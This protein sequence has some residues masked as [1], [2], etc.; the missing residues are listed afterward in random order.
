MTTPDGLHLLSALDLAAAYRSGATSP[1][2]V[3]D[4]LLARVDTHA[5]TLGAFVTVTADRARAQALQA[6]QRFRDGDGDRLPPLYGVPTAIKDLTMTAGVRTMFGSAVMREHVPTVSDEVVVRIEAAGLISLGKTNTP[7]FGSPCYTEPDVAP[8]AR[9]PYDL[10]RSAGGSSGGAAAAV[11][12]GLVPVAHGSDGGGSIRIPASVCGLVGFKPT[13]GRIS[14][15]PVHGD[16]SGLST[17]GC[18]ATTVRD[19]AALLDVMAGHHPGDPTWAPPLP[20]GQTY[21]GWCDRTPAPL[22][23]GCF[24]EP[25][26]SDCEL[27]PHVRGA[28][29][30][31]REL[32]VGLGHEVVDIGPP[33]R[34]RTAVPDF[35]V[36]WAV[37]TTGIPVPVE[38]EHLLRPLTRWLRERGARTS[39]AQYQAA[40]V[41]MRQAA[42]SAQVALH[43]YDAVLTPTLGQLPALVSGLRNDQDPAADFA[44]QKDFTPFTAAWNVTGMPA[45][46]MPTGW[47]GTGLPIGT[48][49][50]GRAGEDHLLLAIAAQVEAALPPLTRAVLG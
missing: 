7:E 12:A 35:E 31:A 9:T 27:D 49:L 15:A 36:V 16:V 2:E 3:V 32:L 45:V 39:A 41:G 28:Y 4:H 19:A 43:P 26:I 29:E 47:S 1:T 10:A 48:M 33:P 24:S 14:A 50:A 37:G 30:Q 46:S 44:A 42:A 18:L 25:L 20:V 17:H 23:I 13:R 21:L 22:R 40:L 8:P 5:D 11:A 34:L 38:A 6:T